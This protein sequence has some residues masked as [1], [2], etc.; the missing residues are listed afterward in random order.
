M[1]AFAI[2]FAVSL[3]CP[4]LIAIADEAGDLPP[5]ILP[6]AESKGGGFT[7][8]SSGN[9]GTVRVNGSSGSASSGEILTEGEVP[10]YLKIAFNANHN[11]PVR[12]DDCGEISGLRT[13]CG[14]NNVYITGARNRGGSS[15]A[16][17]T[18][19]A[20]QSYLLDIY[21]DGETKIDSFVILPGLRMSTTLAKI[22]SGL[23]QLDVNSGAE[24]VDGLVCVILAEP[25]MLGDVKTVHTLGGSGGVTKTYVANGGL[26]DLTELIQAMDASGFNSDYFSFGAVQYGLDADGNVVSVTNVIVTANSSHGTECPIEIQAYTLD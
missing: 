11:K 24:A 22:S 21:V 13:S 26:L 10:Q 1:I 15:G 12:V 18:V 6:G 25:G 14:G 5:V 7:F 2:F 9:G 16:D 17:I 8:T 3:C 23:F 20:P 4:V 19:S